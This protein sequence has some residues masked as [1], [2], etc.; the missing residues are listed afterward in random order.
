MARSTDCISW[1]GKHTAGG[2]AVL[3]AAKRMVYMH[4]VTYEATRGPIPEGMTID[5]LCRNQGCLNPLHMEV[6]TR[7][8]NAR[9]SNAS[10][11]HCPQGHEY[12]EENTDVRLH[13]DGYLCRRCRECHRTKAR[14]RSARK[15]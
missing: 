12:T 11:S 8:E 6:V 1:G 14:A 3:Y 9:R 2:Y 5:H 13:R 4:R 10:V 7:G 15:V